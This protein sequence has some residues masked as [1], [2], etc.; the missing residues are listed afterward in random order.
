MPLLVGLLGAC[1]LSWQAYVAECGNLGNFTLPIHGSS[2]EGE[3]RK[4]ARYDEEDR[5]CR[6]TYFGCFVSG[7]EG[8]ACRAICP[9]AAVFAQHT[10]LKQSI[11]QG[12]VDDARILAESLLYLQ[13][14]LPAACQ[15]HKD[16]SVGCEP[17]LAAGWFSRSTMW[18]SHATD[19][20]AETL[21][22]PAKLGK[23]RLA[24]GRD[25]A[26][27]TAYHTKPGFWR[28]GGEAEAEVLGSA[29]SLHD[30][31]M[32]WYL[33]NKRCYAE[34]HGYHFEF[35]RRA[36]D[37]DLQA[38][39]DGY[40]YS[41]HWVKLM[42]VR[43]ALR[44]Y[45]WVFWIDY[46]ALFANF[47][48]SLDEFLD[49]A[50]AC[51]AVDLVL[52]DGHALVSPNAFLIRSSP[53][54]FRF[55]DAWEAFGR[56]VTR[57]RSKMWELRTFNCALVHV[58]L[59][60]KSG[61]GLRV[62]GEFADHVYVLRR[63]LEK[64]GMGHQTRRKQHAIGKVYFWDPIS[65][66]PRGLLFNVNDAK[67]Q[68]HF[69]EEDLYHLGDLGVHW[70][71]RDKDTPVMRAFA[72]E[73]TTEK[74][75]A[76]WSSPAADLE[77][78][79]QPHGDLN[80]PVFYSPEVALRRAVR[81]AQFH[82]AAVLAHGPE[83]GA[84]VDRMF[85]ISGLWH[86]I[87]LLVGESF[88]QEQIDNLQTEVIRVRR[89]RSF[90]QLPVT[91][92]YDFIYMGLPPEVTQ[93]EMG[94]QVTQAIARLVPGGLLAAPVNNCGH[95][96]TNHYFFPPWWRRTRARGSFEFGGPAKGCVW[97]YQVRSIDAAAY[98]AAVQG[99]QQ[100]RQQAAPQPGR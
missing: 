45:D 67:E 38:E 16:T 41:I 4:Q 7:D 21:L 44:K 6:H 62:C 54:A 29:D 35:E 37:I 59:A 49:V 83:G 90:S 58:M 47:S 78:A 94:S 34:R 81:V 10:L 93:Q 82:D 24:S 56:Q 1:P 23:Q 61:E 12:A 73:L 17:L 50:E 95:S 11:K 75:C 97:A 92:R 28:L 31:P 86:R 76:R 89:L 25:I 8:Q 3:L 100:L 53:W 32:P 55:L 42:A 18:L 60:A 30:V 68:T 91:T 43:A 2:S 79:F 77:E 70:P 65:Q 66:W 52:Q 40:A 99:K 5:E 14:L 15:G 51:S 96:V 98:H 80:S 63:L 69:V 48:Q 57:G 71:R 19:Y 85:D 72:N 87:D 26:V 88:P 84:V 46:D 20:L 27:V 9:I 33:E 36:P 39:V 74:G 64:Y 22:T 13:A